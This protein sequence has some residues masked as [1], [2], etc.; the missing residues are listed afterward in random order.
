MHNSLF[1][2]DLLKRTNSDPLRVA[3]R[4]PHRGVAVDPSARP[5]EGE[6]ALAGS[7]RV[8]G[9]GTP[10]GQAAARDL[11]DFLRLM[12][13]SVGKGSEGVLRVVRDAALPPR[14]CRLSFAPESV[15]IEA[16]DNA[17]IWAGVAWTEREMRVRRGPFL[18][19]GVTERHAAWGTQISQG[20]WGGNYSVPDFSPEYLADDS[21]RMYAHYG[22]NSMMIYGDL[23]CYVRSDVLPE[24]NTPDY[25]QNVAML[26][27]AAA[28]ANVHGVQFSYVVVGP[29][30]RSTHPVFQNHPNAM[31]SGVRPGSGEISIHCLC[32]SDEEVLAFYR[33]TFENLF[34]EVPQLAGLILIIGG[35]SY[36]H[37]HM[38]GRAAHKCPR[39][40]SMPAEDVVANLVDVTAR[41]AQAARA[42]AFVVA[43]PYNIDSWEHKDG[44]PLIKSL[45]K[46]VGFI[47]QM[48]R[49]HLYEKDG[50]QKLVWDYSVD[51]T[52]P[53]DL[54]SKQ[55]ELVKFRGLPLFLR[56]ETGIGLE[57]FQ[58]PYVPAMQRLANKWR[59]VRG[60]APQGVHQAWLF[61][62]MF[63]SRAEELGLWAAYASEVERDD[64]LRQM[65]VR[66]F[67]PD[68]A[69]AA[70]ESWEHMSEAVGH[71][72]SL[73]L[74]NYYVGPG[75]LGPAHPLVP[76]RDDDVPEIF[77]AALFY[78][79]EGEETF[80]R[81]RNVVKESLVLTELQETARSINVH[82]KGKGDGWDIVLREYRAVVEHSRKAYEILA[83]AE[84]YTV[85]P[86][87]A[88]NLREE[89][90]LT[91]LVYRTFLTS[92]NTIDFLYERKQLESTG[93][94]AHAERMR[95]IARAELENARS[96]VH[97]YEEAPWLDLA[98]RTDGVYSPCG[99]MLA[100]KIEWTERYLAS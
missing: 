52:G 5:G 100:A 83:A 33:E 15:T 48:D 16:S 36:Y 61:F 47:N 13:V 93:K 27:D 96:A 21:F 35:E 11:A 62:G 49:T 91:E 71:L 44:L 54:I 18:P 88:R 12:G 19:E 25:E 67:G 89:V 66:D 98:E 68:V 63:G 82:W 4:N 28:R 92:L 32:S 22:I 56:T 34:T 24:L 31:G 57:V 78:L 79:Q 8:E 51:F 45:P 74:A 86:A 90:L 84:G 17:G 53:S 65:A 72:P 1:I 94:A 43:W 2:R 9:D 69:D 77:H 99:D 73:T 46:N 6:F 7:W 59:V 70:L 39:C 42:D 23:L 95:A 97:I 14:A 85:T 55:A 58:Y 76:N 64:F 3:R 40:H 10:P 81:K 87:D 20:P 38:W 37:C 26:K 80:S 41:G 75:F 30:L 50:Y 29:K 60:L